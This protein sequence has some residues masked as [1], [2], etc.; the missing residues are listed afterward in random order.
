MFVP[1]LILSV[2]CQ[3][4]A[5]PVIV[6]PESVH[7]ESCVNTENL[8]LALG[9][10]EEAR[11]TISQFSQSLKGKSSL[12]SSYA[13]TYS[14]SLSQAM[15]TINL[16]LEQ[17]TG[18]GITRS[19]RSA[20]DFVSE[21]GSYLFGFVSASQY[22]ALKLNLKTELS[23]LHEQNNKALR[24]ISQNR[25]EINCAL[26]ELRKVFET[27]SVFKDKWWRVENMLALTIQAS[28]MLQSIESVISV[29]TQIRSDA[30]KH[31]P[32]RFVIPPNQLRQM[33]LEINDDFQGIFPVF[34]SDNVNSYYR[35]SIATTSF[36][37]YKLCQLL[38]IPLL[39]DK[40]KFSISH[41]DCPAGLVCLSNSVGSTMLYLTDFLSCN[42]L[43]FR[44]LPTICRARPCISSDQTILCTMVN[45]T[46]AVIATNKPFELVIQC[47]LKTSLEIQGIYVLSIP[48]ECST[49][50]SLLH[51][52]AITTMSKTFKMPIRALNVPF[53]FSDGLLHINQ[54]NLDNQI[55]EN[56]HIRQ[57]IL[58]KIRPRFDHDKY[59]WKPAHVNRAISI[60]S[61]A[62]VAVCFILVL[63]LFFCGR[64]KLKKLK[65]SNPSQSAFS[66]PCSI[67][68]NL[69]SV[70]ENVKPVSDGVDCEPRKDST[71][72]FLKLKMG[73]NK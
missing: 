18:A 9:R 67:E 64:H 43:H 52:Q 12:Y 46:T 13:G 36:F 40:Q 24:D 41:L 55:F 62:A 47:K 63:F 1:L 44:E 48:P 20:F 8:F 5:K 37:D 56:P 51:I 71:G 34:N 61:S 27:I 32:S 65:S 68:E 49:F 72:C 45:Q 17:L 4:L 29:I 30:D 3:S 60:S 16:K 11:S 66:S 53:S 54:S 23:I 10:L 50:S 7:Y 6:T 22:K 2:L 28:A 25:D 69:Q 31:L 21:A 38:K 58:P 35:L 15:Q 57:M 19:K 14:R 42:S 73:G 59:E 39:S 70:E 33:L 26:N